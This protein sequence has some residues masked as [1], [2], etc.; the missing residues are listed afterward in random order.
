MAITTKQQLIDA[1]ERAHQD[2]MRLLAAM[3]DEEKTAPILNEGWSVKDSLAHLIAWE[4]M[5]MDWMSRSVRGEE[6]K[7]FIPG[8]QYE[9]EEQRMPVMEA[10]NQQLYEESKMRPL[11]DVVQDLR[12]THRVIMNFISQ[13]DEKDIFEPNRFAWRNGSP[14]LDMLGGNTYEHYAEHQG[15]I[16]KGRAKG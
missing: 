3:S 8:F 9:S 15:W 2:M 11:D 12:A 1:A 14:A 6:V 5:A 10:L 4:K 13:L 16:L 7:R